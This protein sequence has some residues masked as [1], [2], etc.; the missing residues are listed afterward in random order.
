MSHY[1]E[2]INKVLE[3]IT[4]SP[5]EYDKLYKIESKINSNLHDFLEEAYAP[6]ID[7]V[8]VGSW[9]KD[10][11]LPGTSDIDIFILFPRGVLESEFETQI[12]PVIEQC[13][14]SIGSVPRRDYA[15]HPY[16]TTE[17]DGCKVDI[18]PCHQKYDECIISAVDRTPLHTVYVNSHIDN[19][20][21]GEVRLLKQFLKAND[22]YGANETVKGFSGYLCE[23]L[24]LEYGGFREV[25]ESEL[26]E[27]YKEG[28]IDF[29]DPVDH[30]R[31]VAAALSTQKYG[32]F[33][34]TSRKLLNGITKK[35]AP[36]YLITKYFSTELEATEPLEWFKIDVLFRATSIYVQY[37]HIRTNVDCE[38]SQFLS[39][40][41]KNI[42]KTIR[43]GFHYLKHTNFTTENHIIGVVE[44]EDNILP[45]VET[46]Q[47]PPVT[48]KKACD[49]FVAKNKNVY[50]NNGHL[51]TDVK[52][53]NT[54]VRDEWEE[55]ISLNLFLTQHYDKLAESEKQRFQHEIKKIFTMGG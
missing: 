26:T 24:I 11:F 29:P 49:S 25:L 13:V 23:L 33:L 37:Q 38:Y 40:F 7:L 17:V 1:N 30:N 34:L 47:G 9:A 22:L 46:H 36:Q 2:V 8:S 51:M 55:L 6:Y 32:E 41:Q 19:N 45:N 48:L 18:V 31:N 28:S 20:L 44:Y 4:P 16:I 43:D 35:L 14:R 10:T 3:E 53:V 42:N 39:K 15:S 50:V 5:E 54:N 52:R 27:F 21:R 12:L